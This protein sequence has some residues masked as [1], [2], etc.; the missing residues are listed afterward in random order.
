M[1][2]QRRRLVRRAAGLE[3]ASKRDSQ[4]RRAAETA[5]Q[6]QLASHLD[7]EAAAMTRGAR[8]R[9][10]CIEDRRGYGKAAGQVEPGDVRAVFDLD[11]DAQIERGRERRMAIDH[12]VLPE[13]QYFPGSAGDHVASPSIHERRGSK[14]I[15]REARSAAA[16]LAPQRSSADFS[17][18]TKPCKSARAASMPPSWCARTNGSATPATSAPSANAFAASKPLRM[19]PEAMMRIPGAAV[20]SVATQAA[21]GMPQ[22]ESCPPSSRPSVVLARSCSTRGQEVPPKPLT[23]TARTPLLAS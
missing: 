21:V 8:K 11:R 10:Y 23:S 2:R 4:R 5:A 7:H 14:M 18:A 13:E 17:D 20:R 1:H 3:S 12:R 16:S 15:G 19:P 9:P 6:R 22:P